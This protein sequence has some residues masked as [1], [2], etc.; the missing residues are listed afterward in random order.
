M[1]IGEP[2]WILRKH[3][4]FLGGGT[5]ML[6]LQSA[7]GLDCFNIAGEFLLGASDTQI[8]I[9]DVKISCGFRHRFSVQGFIGGSSIRKGLPFTIDFC[10]NRQFVQFFIRCRFIPPQTVLELPLVEYLVIPRLP[11]CAGVDA[12]IGFTNIQFDDPPLAILHTGA[13]LA[14]FILNLG[15]R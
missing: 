8:I 10:G 9:R 4:L 11:M 5:A 12:Y 6:L 3:L 7:Q 14:Q 15:L 13:M 1:S 2:F